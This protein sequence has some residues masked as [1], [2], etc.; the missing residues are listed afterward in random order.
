VSKRIL[1]FT[2]HFYPYRGGLENAVL[3]LY[4]TMKVLHPEIEIDVICNNTED[5]S[6]YEEYRGLNVYRIACWNILGGTYS[7]PKPRHV[8]KTL[9]RLKN[10]RY[11]FVNTHT[12]FFIN[13]AIGFFF[14]KL[15]GFRLI[16]TEHGASFTKLKNPL[17]TLISFV[18]DQTLGRL[19]LTQA[20]DVVVV[21][22]AAGRF[23]RRLGAKD[24][25]HIPNG[26]EVADKVFGGE[27]SKKEKN[28]LV[29]VGRL[30]YGKGVQDL[31][32]VLKDIPGDWKLRIVGI[33]NY[34]EV[35]KRRVREYALETNVEFLGLL[36]SAEVHHLLAKSQIFIN[37]TYT[38][39]FG[40]TT[41]E[42]GLEGCAVVASNVGGQPD[43]I[44][45]GTDGFLVD[46]FEKKEQRRFEL[47]R[48]RID[49]LLDDEKL[50]RTFGERIGRKVSE[51]FNWERTAGAYYRF[52]E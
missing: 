22:R 6:P 42:A 1:V 45:D 20:D 29:F 26:I 36:E 33:G 5:V 9:S 44:D 11:R 32:F 19:I 24:M 37:P 14:A 7:I 46:G 12:R 39:G 38:E 48:D 51:R 15:C 35:L 13:S 41:M 16:H 52:A 10:R 31:L 43:I 17:V 23:A 3:E 34:Q 2:N 27:F 21:S 49:K 8:L 25:Q 4:S 18:F 28:S 40:I 30:V 50:C 47:L